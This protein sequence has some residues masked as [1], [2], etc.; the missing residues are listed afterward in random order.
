MLYLM[1]QAVP[2]TRHDF[3]VVPAPPAIEVR[4]HRLV[5]VPPQLAA[6]HS[7]ANN[8]STPANQQ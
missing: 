5:N 8:C 6:T 7:P 4:L 3:D 2:P 1:R